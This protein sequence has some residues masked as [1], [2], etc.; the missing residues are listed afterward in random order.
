MLAMIIKIAFAN[1]VYNLE[2]GHTSSIRERC[3]S[4]AITDQLVNC[5]PKP[6]IILNLVVN[7]MRNPSIASN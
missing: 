1:P 2:T 4:E 5:I 7:L 3:T 6:V